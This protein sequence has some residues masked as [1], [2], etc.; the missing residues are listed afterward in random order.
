VSDTGC[1]GSARFCLLGPLEVV[2]AAGTA[3]P[4]RAGKQR[5]VLATLLLG[6]GTTIS[7]ESMS[8]ALWDASPPPNA[9]ALMRTYVMRLR[10][11]LGPVGA[12]VVS[13]PPGW[14]IVLHGPEEFDLAE[15][16]H[17][18]SAARSAGE[19]GDLKQVAALLTKALSQWRGEPLIDVPSAALARRDVGR[20]PELRIQL[21][22]ARIDADL[23]LGRHAEVVPELRR[24]A[25]EHP[26]HEHI[27][28]QLMVA[29][30][31]C[32]YKAAALDAICTPA[33]PFAPFIPLIPLIPPIPLTPPTPP[34]SHTT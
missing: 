31:R 16:E 9:S 25:A 29:Y 32:G 5:V 18:R 23:L 30:Y 8:E 28:V 22:L 33:A 1:E 6:G 34:D 20:L 10:R 21:T 15:V 2:D 11:T 19:A 12:R 26:R 3:W 14:T 24:L 13:Q 7:A 17:L 27:R 4:V